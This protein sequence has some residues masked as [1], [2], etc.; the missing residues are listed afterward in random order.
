VWGVYGGLALAV[1]LALM[2]ARADHATRKRARPLKRQKVR[3]TI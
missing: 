3:S 1:F 2:F